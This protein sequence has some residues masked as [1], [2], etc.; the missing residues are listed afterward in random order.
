[1]TNPLVHFL[2]VY[3]HKSRLLTQQRQFD[4]ST[5]AVEAYFAMEQAY[6][7]DSLVEI[8]LIGSDS[9]DTIRLTHANYFDGKVAISEY[10]AGI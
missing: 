2:L 7:D 5:A 4:D 3:D 6:K 1:M 9:M 8:V 10:L